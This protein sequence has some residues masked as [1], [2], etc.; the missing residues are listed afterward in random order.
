MIKRK[1][2]EA[3]VTKNVRIREEFQKPTDSI[4][5]SPSKLEIRKDHHTD[6]ICLEIAKGHL[7]S[8]GELWNDL[9][10]NLTI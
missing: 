5:T 3:I 1:L 4:D 2:N 10:P 7:L 8:T 6:Y 9:E